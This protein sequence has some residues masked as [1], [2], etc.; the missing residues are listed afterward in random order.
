M[1]QHLKLILGTTGDAEVTNKL[2]KKLRIIRNCLV[3][4]SSCREIFLLHIKRVDLS[5]RRLNPSTQMQSRPMLFCEVDSF[6]LN[7]IHLTIT[8]F[9]LFMNGHSDFDLANFSKYFHLKTRF[10]NILITKVYNI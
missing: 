2:K 4:N 3:L 9:V 7:G 1:T 10:I 8:Y 5:I 6:I